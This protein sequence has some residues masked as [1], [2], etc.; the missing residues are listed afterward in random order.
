[1]ATA[2][3]PRNKSRVLTKI[4]ATLLNAI[5]ADAPAGRAGL[6]GYMRG[7]VWVS[8]GVPSSTIPDGMLAKDLIL[9]TTN[10]DVYRF[11][12]GTTYVKITATS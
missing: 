2:T 10:D 4:I 7:K 5:E 1:M 6:F 8:A 3:R 9:D 12:T 11:I